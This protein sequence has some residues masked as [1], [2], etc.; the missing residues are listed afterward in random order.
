MQRKELILG[1]D[2]NINVIII[3][4]ATLISA[5]GVIAAFLKSAEKFINRPKE[6]KESMEELKSET[7][8]KFEKVEKDIKGIKKEQVVQTKCLLAIMDGLKQL[9][10]N[11]EVT[12]AKNELS[13]Y[14]LSQAHDNNE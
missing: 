3:S 11:G 14:L 13:D 5:L 1:A 10:C 8:K 7:N 9:G 6:N 2:L 4:T 12:E